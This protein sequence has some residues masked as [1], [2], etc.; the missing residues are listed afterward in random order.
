MDLIQLVYASQPFGFDEASLRGILMD[1]RRC[2]ARDGVT[3]TLLCRH[4]IYLQMLEGP[5]ETVAATY[6][7]ILKDDR[8]MDPALLLRA[9]ASG[10][11]FPDWAMRHDP[12]ASVIWSPEEVAAGHLATLPPDALLDVFARL[13]AGAADG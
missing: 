5:E 9:P 4:D 6:A 3:G 2:N 12:A 7:R 13:A 11:L 8:H 10:R 1:A